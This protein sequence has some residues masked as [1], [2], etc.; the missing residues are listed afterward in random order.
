MPDMTTP[1]E[2]Y[3]ALTSWAHWTE[4]PEENAREIVDALERAGC[5]I[6]RRDE[7]GAANPCPECQGIGSVLVDTIWQRCEVC[8]GSGVRPL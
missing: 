3:L 4:E 7:G 2:A 5:V 8:S 1:A 6:V